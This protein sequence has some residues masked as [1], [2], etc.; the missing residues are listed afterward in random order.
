MNRDELVALSQ[1]QFVAWLYY[2]D[3]EN[4]VKD[5]FPLAELSEEHI[6][7]RRAQVELAA[8]VIQDLDKLIPRR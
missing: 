6:V 3:L 5:M 7:E 1:C 4:K 2:R 8:K